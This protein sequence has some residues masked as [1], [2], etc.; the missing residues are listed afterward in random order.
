MNGYLIKA[1]YLSGRSIGRSYFL[2]KGGYVTTPN[3]S[4]REDT[5]YKTLRI[6]K[7]QCKRLLEKNEL[8]YNAETRTRNY[9][10]KMNQFVSSN[11]V[12]EK[13]SY[14]PFEVQNVHP[15]RLDK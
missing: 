14:E 6:A 5:V 4:Q 10:T 13:M 1:T 3:A 7:A 15:D 9:R 2:R 12:Y 11:R 8:D